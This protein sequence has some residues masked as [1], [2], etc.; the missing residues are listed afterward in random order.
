MG[1]VAPSISDQEVVENIRRGVTAAEATLYE[2]FSARVYY[3]ALRELHSPQDAEDARAETFLRVLQAVRSEA[4]QSPQA[5][6]AFILS[7]VRNVVREQIRRYSRTEQLDSDNVDQQYK[8]SP[9]PAFI[10][11]D[12][13]AEIDRVIQRLK[14]REQQF[15]RMYYYDELT[16]EEIARRLDVKPERVRLIKSRALKSFRQHYERLTKSGYK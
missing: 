4:L 13:K 8:F 15:L 3:L 11:A 6:S 5:L 16:V 9:Q 1:Q 14:P 7:T 2:K 12:V 10:D